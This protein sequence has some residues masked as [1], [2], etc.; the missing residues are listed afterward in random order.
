MEGAAPPA[1]R[2]ENLL[3]TSVIDGATE[4]IGA[5]VN[6]FLLVVNGEKNHRYEW[7]KFDSWK[8]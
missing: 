1:V 5:A 3:D 4:L 2:V 6:G 8:R 7:A